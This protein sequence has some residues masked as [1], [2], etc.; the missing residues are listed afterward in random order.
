MIWYSLAEVIPQKWSLSQLRAIIV[1]PLS[2]S[3]WEICLLPA[4]RGGEGHFEKTFLTFWS[5]ICFS[6]N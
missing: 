4:E 6:A 5:I 3:F 2:S 1:I